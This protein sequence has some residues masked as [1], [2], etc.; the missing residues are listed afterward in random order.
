MSEPH[1]GRIRR[2]RHVGAVCTDDA[3]V[4]L[5]GLELLVEL[6]DHAVPLELRLSGERPLSLGG[7]RRAALRILRVESHEQL[8]EE[9]S[10]LGRFGVESH[11]L[12]SLGRHVDH[13]ELVGGDNRETT[14]LVRDE[15]AVTCIDAVH[16]AVA[17]HLG[18]REILEREGAAFD[19]SRFPI[20]GD[21]HGIVDRRVLLRRLRRCATRCR[22]R[23]VEIAFVI[24]ASKGGAGD[25]SDRHCQS[26]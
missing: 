21:V 10:A 4:E 25:E 23:R 9:T 16:V 20:G 7:Q 2:L 24:G 17:A 26:A 14:R 12:R 11:G 15:I 1:I 13:G 3:D 19:R 22:I 6:V 8:L 18:T 5:A